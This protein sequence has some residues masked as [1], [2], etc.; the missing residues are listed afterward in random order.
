MIHSPRSIAVFLWLLPFLAW[1]GFGRGEET[2]FSGAEGSFLAQI[3]AQTPPGRA[4]SLRLTEEGRQLLENR[5]YKKALSKLEKAIAIDSRNRY[6]YYYLGEA[7]YLLTEHQQ[8]LNFLEIAETL[9]AEEPAWLA[10]V[11]ALEGKNYE[12][13][14]FFGRAD[15]SYA[16]AL[17]LDPKN[18]IALQGLITMHK[19]PVTPSP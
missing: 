10:Q 5:E 15:L 16:R 8:S 11:F 3:N 12:A 13:L 17:K 6:A 2:I 7:H 14:R 1:P 9:F 4:A 19:E 18:R